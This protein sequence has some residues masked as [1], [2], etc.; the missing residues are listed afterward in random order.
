MY[1]ARNAKGLVAVG[2]GGGQSRT[3][4]ARIFHF[5]PFEGKLSALNI[6]GKLRLF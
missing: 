2:V 6:S 3:D 4:K 1:I 5:D